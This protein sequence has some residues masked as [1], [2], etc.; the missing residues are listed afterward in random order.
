MNH[1]TQIKTARIDH[2]ESYF[3]DV[4]KGM[5]VF[6]MIWGHCIQYCA[7]DTVDFFGDI[8]F[9]TIYTFHMPLFM[10][11]SGYLF[12]Y[13][14]QKRKLKDLL[15]HRI[16][17]MLH[18]IVAGTV[19]N[20]VLL[21]VPSF[22]LANRF[23]VLFGELFRGIGYNFWFLWA[24][25]ISSVI[26]GVGC[27]MT[28]NPAAQFVV[29]VFGA[30]AVLLVP[31]WDMTLFMYPYF[32]A[33]FFCAMYR[34]KARKIYKILRFAAVIVF[35]LML[36]LYESKHYIYLTP[37]YSEILGLRAS[38]EIAGFRCMIGFAGSI[39]ML[40]FA[41]LMI[42]LGERIRP[43][44]AVLK[45]LAQLGRNSLQMYCL[46]APLLSGYLPHLYAKIMEPFGCNLFAKNMVIYDFVFTP[47]AAVAWSAMLYCAV[48]MLKKTKLHK[49]IFGR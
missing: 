2:K 7:L 4:V 15:V 1:N 14:F 6:L 17:G 5:A 42:W 19:L 28:D 34:E 43:A 16:Q 3:W 37:M 32:V 40:A 39:S 20:N 36:P 33:G 47:L 49:L 48:V 45:A 12:Y 46:S 23:D 9:K 10:L 26:V 38:L 44:D 29:A 21:L 31:Q 18:P 27:K 25:L 35:L 24:V 41:E 13:S 11:V 22:V 30:F 8:A